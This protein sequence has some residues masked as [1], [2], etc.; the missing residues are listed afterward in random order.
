M[1]V[2]PADQARSPK[3][4][5]NEKI[6]LIVLAGYMR[7]LSSYFVKSFENKILNIHPA[8]LPAFGGVDAIKRAY[9]YGC[10]L[11]GV[12][13]HFVD[14]Q[15][16][17]GPIILQ[18]PIEIKKDMSL[19]KLEEEIHKLEH[20]LY[21]LAIKLFVNKRLKLRGRHVKITKIT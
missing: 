1:F 19:N 17:H 8:I 12:T 21:P 15:V 16:D 13:V 4:L 10:K 5:R 20:K 7:V 2:E 9:D 6:D 3:I 14:E 18:A 11:T